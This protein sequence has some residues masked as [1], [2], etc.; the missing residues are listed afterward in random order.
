VGKLIIKI[1]LLLSIESDS[2]I[3]PSF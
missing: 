2:L 1:K 3:F